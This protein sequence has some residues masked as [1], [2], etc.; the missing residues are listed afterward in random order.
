MDSPWTITT[1]SL[2]C[3]LQLVNI[4]G[5]ITFIITLLSLNPGWQDQIEHRMAF[6]MTAT[7]ITIRSDVSSLSKHRSVFL[8]YLMA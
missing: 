6:H 8:K 2:N 3:S 4:Y 5:K 1:L 7:N